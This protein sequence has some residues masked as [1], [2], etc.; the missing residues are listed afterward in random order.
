LAAA[1][2]DLRDRIR[3]GYLYCET[4]KYGNPEKILFYSTAMGL[5]EAGSTHGST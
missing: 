1:F 4:D 5:L 2:P 3:P